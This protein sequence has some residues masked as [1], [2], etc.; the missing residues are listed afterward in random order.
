MGMRSLFF[1]VIPHQ[2][3]KAKVGVHLV[4]GCDLYMGEYGGHKTSTKAGAEPTPGPAPVPVSRKLLM[5]LPVRR[6]VRE[7]FSLQEAE[8][9]RFPAVFCRVLLDRT[10]GPHDVNPAPSAWLIAWCR[11]GHLSVTWSTTR[12]WRSAPRVWSRGTPGET[13]LFGDTGVWPLYSYIDFG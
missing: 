8:S 11:T 5:S 4:L 9:C 7:P 12:L 1:N 2:K 3:I 13:P 6:F 10:P